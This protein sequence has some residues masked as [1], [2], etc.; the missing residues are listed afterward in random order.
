MTLSLT[1]DE[2]HLLDRGLVEWG[3]PAR[4]TDALATAMGFESVR[5]LFDQSARI[6][7][8][9]GSGKPLSAWDWTRMLL[10]TEIRVRE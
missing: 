10:A 3:G 7:L 9:L 4:C 6:R 2:R 8:A 5:D 1:D